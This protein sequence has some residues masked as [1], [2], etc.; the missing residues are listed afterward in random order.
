MVNGFVNGV[1]FAF[2]GDEDMDDYD[3]CSCL[4]TALAVIV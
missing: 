3:V 1:P 2:G 4:Y